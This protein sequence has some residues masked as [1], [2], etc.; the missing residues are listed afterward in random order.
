MV[1]T[2]NEM[3]YLV[4]A[5]IVQEIQTHLHNF[6]GSN[7]SKYNDLY[8]QVHAQGFD[9]YTLRI[10]EKDFDT[11]VEVCLA[12]LGFAPSGRIPLQ[13]LKDEVDEID[14]VEELPF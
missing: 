6:V 13:I 9:S 5:C 12:K 2:Q 14:K 3:Y 10:Y 8:I 7:T 4:E 11:S 1:Q